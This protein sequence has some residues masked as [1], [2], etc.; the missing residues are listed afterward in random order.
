[1]PRIDWLPSTRLSSAPIV[2][3]FGR[4]L[5]GVVTEADV[6]HTALSDKVIDPVQSVYAR[7]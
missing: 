2:T 6:A 5:I 3:G 7:S 4:R 1:M